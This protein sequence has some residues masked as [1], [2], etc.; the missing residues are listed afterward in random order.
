MSNLDMNTKAHRTSV[1]NRQDR[2]A[3]ILAL[4]K[5]VCEK[6]GGLSAIDP[7]GRFQVVDTTLYSVTPK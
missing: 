4:I 7:K 5:R 2:N 3:E 6:Q 1:N